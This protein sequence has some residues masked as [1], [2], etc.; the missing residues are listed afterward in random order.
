MSGARVAALAR[1]WI[2]TPWCHGAAC[3]GAGADCLGLVR[4]VWRELY[5]TVVPERPV[6]PL[7]WAEAGAPDALLQGVGRHLRPLPADAP[8]C[9][10][11][12][13]VFQ[14]S[15]R[16]PARHLGVATAAGPQGRFVHAC[17]GTG[18]VEVS[19]SAP[20]RRRLVARFAFP[21]V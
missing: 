13:L 11:D 15:A 16:G 8:M 4:G 20:W 1:G 14:L 19:L 2:G 9:P 3:R 5:G 12:V 17:S 10:G 7:D 18:V 21:E 6:Y